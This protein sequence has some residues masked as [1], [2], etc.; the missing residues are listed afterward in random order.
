MSGHSSVR[1]LIRTY[2]W[3]NTQFVNMIK[4]YFKLAWRNLLKNKTSSTI[5]IGGLAVGMSVAL[6]IG[7]WVWDEL[8][9]DKYHG[10]YDHIAQVMQHQSDNGNINS[11]ASVSFPMGKE[12]QSEYGSNFKYV[13][14]SS[15][16]GDHILSYSDQKFSESGIYM[17]ADA[18]R[19][20]SLKMIE[21]NDDALKE[22]G[23]VIISASTAKAIFGNKNA[24]NHLMRID[25]KLSVKV[26][27][28]FED[29]PTNTTFHGLDFIAPWDLYKTSEN[30]IV[31]SDKENKWDNNSFKLFVQIPDHI[32]FAAVD[33][34][35]I[36]SK[37]IHVAPEDKIYH[38][39][40]FLNPMRDWHLRSHWDSNGVRD[41][42]FIVYVRLFGIVG[43]F[44]L[45]LA[46]IN[47][48]NLSTARS[49]RRA[50]EVGIRKTIGSL[51]SQ[52]IWQFY[53]ESLMIVIIAFTL[54]IFLVQL[55]LPF[56]NNIAS[57]Q[58]A[59][60]Y[61]SLSFWMI[62]VAFA[63]ITGV[64]AGSYPALYLSSFM[65]IRV[66]KGTFKAGQLASLP[67]KVLVVLQFTIS[68]VLV[69]GTIVIYNQVQYTKNR[70]I[71]YE[72]NGLMMMRMK[73]PDFYGKFGLLGDELKKSG[74]VKEFAESSSPLTNLWTTNDGFSWPGKSPGLSSDF[75]TIWVT[76]DFGKTVNWR[77][78]EGRDFSKEFTT[79]S[80]AVLL[81]ETAVKYMGLKSPIGTTIK[82][83]T[84]QAAKDYKV[85]GVLKD[86]VMDS[87]FDPVQKTIYFLDYY[88]VNWI[89][90]R[91]NPNAGAS[92][93]ISK[94]EAIFKR[95][96]P[97]APFDYKFADEEFASKFAAE[98]RIGKLST[99]FA[100]LAIFISCLG[101]F[102]LASFVAEQR[103]KEIG[104]RKLLG[105][106]LFDLWTL[107][108]KE[109]VLLVCI[110]LL[111]ASPLAYYL[112]YRWLLNYQYRTVLSWWIFIVA[113][114]GA[115][116]ITIITV[117]IQAIK[118]A[119]VNP[120]KSLKTE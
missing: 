84:G 60:P 42:G 97:S 90:M 12:L 79:D 67:R 70:P 40:V 7:L 61:S 118:A 71:G 47:F 19:M 4:S 105:A 68:I 114:S 52:I 56:F 87:P 30:W 107:L 46:C 48:M 92:S 41:G 14:M 32:N 57:K 102:G 2:P 113:A 99:I 51:R 86:V 39:K 49:E 16:R 93:S 72:R 8:S 81:N 101:L 45:L 116:I 80:A 98:E 100:A 115:L 10:N 64:I 69:I 44:V 120:V 117:S 111:L 25:N 59:V 9:F 5:N 35:I 74:A 6:I 18:T 21:G 82:W 17:D 36:D 110:S 54:S 58:L 103:S 106:S 95:I 37:Q 109:F 91:L 89:I 38:T 13:V 83:G 23:S 108:S 55:S 27:G 66:L 22:P 112:M 50:K 73:S 26:T 29:L 28:V 62:G 34:K 76:H 43:I 63:M 3:Y 1:F 94:T 20:F 11:F 15:F 88:N 119:V 33:K 78:T 104:L 85:V 77:F 31:N 75:G 53:G 65:P 96:I 24:L